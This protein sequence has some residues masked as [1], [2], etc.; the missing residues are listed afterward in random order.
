MR[1]VEW[2]LE[3]HQHLPL[4]QEMRGMV[5]DG[6]RWFQGSLIPTRIPAALRQLKLAV[7]D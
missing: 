1:Y 7:L 5:G 4:P 2:V 6:K 3:R